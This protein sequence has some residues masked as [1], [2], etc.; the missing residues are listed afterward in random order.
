MKSKIIK[1]QVGDFVKIERF[2]QY[3]GVVV[4]ENPNTGDWY[5][6]KLS[7]ID[8]LNTNE[9]VLTYGKKVR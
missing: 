9:D 7:D 3:F 6:I 1:T 8:A 2:Q 4:Y 5:V